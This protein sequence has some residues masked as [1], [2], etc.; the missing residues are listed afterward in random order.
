[1]ASADVAA[2]SRRFLGRPARFSVRPGRHCGGGGACECGADSGASLYLRRTRPRP[3]SL[4][5]DVSPACFCRRRCRWRTSRLLTWPLLLVTSV[6][7]GA[8]TRGADSGVGH[9][10]MTVMGL[11]GLRMQT[12]APLYPAVSLVAAG[13]GGQALEGWMLMGRGEWM[14]G[15]GAVPAAGNCASN[16]ASCGGGGFSRDDHASHFPGASDATE[17]AEDGERSH[18][19]GWRVR[20]AVGGEV[21][22][23]WPPRLA[24]ARAGG[25]EGDCRR[26]RRSGDRA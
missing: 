12:G 15:G 6:A 9:D 19:G 25:G 26:G 11:V 23:A 7:A 14:G 21:E 3:R 24:V 18:P 16:R 1:M 8:I 22:A 5:Q 20:P 4:V 2:W 10:S 13:M 17:E